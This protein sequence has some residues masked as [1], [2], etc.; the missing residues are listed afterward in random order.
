MF[1][2]M[3]DDDLS[4]HYDR[5]KAEIGDRFKVMDAIRAEWIVRWAKKNA[6]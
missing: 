2:E 1:D 5:M 3:N 6:V 4:R